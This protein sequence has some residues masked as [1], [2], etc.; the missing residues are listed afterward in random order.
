MVAR[1]G[2]QADLQSRILAV[3]AFVLSREHR[4]IRRRFS[5]GPKGRIMSRE[6]DNEAIVNRWFAEYW[7]ES[8]NP[9]IVDELCAPDVLVQFLLQAPR[10]G[11]ADV[12][13]FMA[14][15][16]EAFPDLRVAPAADF[17]AER[18]YVVGRWVGSGTHTGPA[19]CDFLV[20]CLP[21]SS[22]R[23]MRFTGTTV[24]R[25]QNGKIAEQIGLDD[26]VTASLLLGLT[27]AA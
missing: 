16:R 24:L 8:W 23:Q 4:A 27:G 19:Y 18:D 13:T 10:R 17:V 1:N 6:Q 15:L 11:R 3:D 21:A 14:E 7:G 5:T 12:R 20:G 22:G 26:E 9:T 25:V 2:V